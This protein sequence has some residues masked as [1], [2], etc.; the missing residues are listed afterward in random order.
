MSTMSFNLTLPNELLDELAF[1]VHGV[2][3]VRG[4]SA[5]GVLGMIEDIMNIGLEE[6]LGETEDFTI[7]PAGPGSFTI[8]I[9]LIA[10]S[11]VALN[12]ANIESIE[13]MS[14]DDICGVMDEIVMAGLDELLGHSEGF[15]L[16][17]V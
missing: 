3:T 11:D 13:G 2:E 6:H 15:N 5:A 7:H 1:N 9:P 4:L 8:Q 12:V 16:R 17:A 14:S 10:L